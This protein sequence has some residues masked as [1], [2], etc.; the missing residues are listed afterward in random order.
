M[1][2]TMVLLMTCLLLYACT[3]EPKIE[4]D[5]ELYKLAKQLTLKYEAL[6]PDS[7]KVLVRTDDFSVRWAELLHS[8]FATDGQRLQQLRYESPNELRATIRERAEAYALRKHL[9]QLA[10][11]A[12][13]TLTE[14][15]V[16]SRYLDQFAG[17]T[18]EEAFTTQMQGFGIEVEN[19]KE[20][21]RKNLM[22]E[23]YVESLL[24]DQYAVTEAEV[25]QVYEQGKAVT[26]RH[27]LLTT[28]DQNDSA[29]AEIRAQMAEILARARAGED[30]AELARKYSED[31]GS[32]SKGGLYV[33]FERADLEPTFA[34]AAFTLPP[35]SI[36][37]VE[38]AYGYHIL[39]VIE[40]KPY[41][42]PLEEVEGDIKEMLQGPKMQQA[43]HN[44]LTE[45]EDKIGLKYV[46]AG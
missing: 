10:E 6:H 25:E 16:Q 13:I 8:M 43:Y 37:T 18:S 11:D 29:G 45:L 38:T 33:D 7:N 17:R 12:D 39:K 46:A 31:E 1:N 3:S 35:D 28:E 21:L 23:K 40:R 15:E 2:R 42:Q 9:L 4:K 44:Y 41:T 26:F 32:K 24:A 5:S 36:D 34:E 19:V 14:S 22:I 30:F 20:E 27:I